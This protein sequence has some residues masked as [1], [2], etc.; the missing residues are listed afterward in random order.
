LFLP[1]FGILILG[2]LTMMATHHTLIQR[3]HPDY[4][5][6]SLD[7]S[8]HGADDGQ[9]VNKQHSV[10]PLEQGESN[11]EVKK[12]LR[13]DNFTLQNIGY[14][15]LSVCHKIYIIEIVSEESIDEFQNYTNHPIIF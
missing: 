8:S 15:I 1:A 3:I 9:N 5:S 6:Q 10:Q 2:T 4:M 7:L 13:W 12:D 11:S 14:N